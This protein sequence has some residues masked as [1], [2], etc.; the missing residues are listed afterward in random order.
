MLSSFRNQLSRE[1][2][3]CW[4]RVK[5]LESRQE[6][7]PSSDNCFV[8]DF[9]LALKSSSF[10]TQPFYPVLLYHEQVGAIRIAPNCQNSPILSNNIL[11]EV[12]TLNLYS[13]DHVIIPIG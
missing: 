7:F 3:V 1:N 13:I 6:F 8:P 10:Y 11:V 12:T 2:N 5:K 4:G 9:Y